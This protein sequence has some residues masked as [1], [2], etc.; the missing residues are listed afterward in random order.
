VTPA[1]DAP[2]DVD[3]ARRIDG[4]ANRFFLD[5]LLRGA[6]PDDLVAD[7][8][9]V[10]DFAHVHDGDLATIATPLDVVGINYYSRHVVAA[11][12]PGEQPEAYWR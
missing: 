11:P 9:Q 10:T 8:T 4:L 1:S 6:Y 7:L 2:D 3:A 5:P 12:I